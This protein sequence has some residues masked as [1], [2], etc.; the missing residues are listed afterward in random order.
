MRVSGLAATAA[1]EAAWSIKA[2]QAKLCTI[3]AIVVDGVF[4]GLSP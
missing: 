1:F 2:K 3:F 4:D